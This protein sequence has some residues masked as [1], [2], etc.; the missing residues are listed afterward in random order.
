MAIIAA[1]LLV[2]FRA[3]IF[4]YTYL[5]DNVFVLDSHWFLR[6]LANIGQAFV[7]EVFNSHAAAAYYRPLLTLSFMVDAHTGGVALFMYHL[8]NM[9]LHM[10]ASCLVFSFLS[11]FG[12]KRHLSFAL[13]LVFAVHPVLAQA[14]A[15]IPGRN[16]SL[17]AIFALSAMI[18]LVR[19]WQSGKIRYLF[20]H[21]F[22]FAC[23]LF[24]KESMAFFPFAGILW[25]ILSTFT[26]D[27]GH[28]EGNAVFAQS[29]KGWKLLFRKSPRLA[30]LIAAWAAPGVLWFTLRKIAL[31]N[32][33]HYAPADIWQSIVHNASAT[34]LYLGKIVFPFNLSALPTLQDSTLVYGIIASMLFAAAIVF[35]AVR[36]QKAHDNAPPEHGGLPFM[37]TLLFGLFWFLLFLVPSFIRPDAAY[38]AYFLEHRVYVPLIGL[39]LIAAQIDFIKKLDFRKAPSWIIVGLAVCALSFINI[40]HLAVFS[41]GFVFWENAVKNSP[42]HPLAHKNLGALY[43]LDGKIDLAEKEYL[44]AIDHYPQ[45]TM[46]HNNLGLIYSRRGELLKAQEEFKK[47]L[48]INPNYDNAFFN[49]GL[50]CYQVGNRKDAETLWRRTL[51]VNPDYTGAMKWLGRLYRETGDT[52]NS[53]RYE[54]MAAK[55][56]R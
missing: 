32:P 15:W 42:R 9:L 48:A 11:T 23:G 3:L 53:L 33:I 16:D 21:C 56:T 31:A 12:V 4:G 5:D 51:E 49:W 55:R 2:Y 45:E 13:S 41:N 46:V 17:L 26:V 35:S 19:Y 20:M 37:S 43:Y 30:G 7:R 25:T 34:L 8:T 10:A 18:T 14:V 29:G 22:F 52:V 39:L 38:P 40:R 6:D 27:H 1:V 28:R 47:E 24:T 54:E 44:Q 50:L 36:S